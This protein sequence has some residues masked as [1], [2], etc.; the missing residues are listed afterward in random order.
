VSLDYP[1]RLRV[2]RAG[3]VTPGAYD[4]ETGGF[5][6]STSGDTVIYDGPADV[7]D[8]GE[9]IPRTASGQPEKIANA[10]AFLPEYARECAA[11]DDPGG[12]GRGVLPQERPLG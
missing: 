6:P 9:S 5:T 10:T 3:T 12:Y 2:T 1:Y 4:P 11:G 8:A 7:Q